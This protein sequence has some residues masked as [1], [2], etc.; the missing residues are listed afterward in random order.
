[1]KIVKLA[2][3][4]TLTAAVLTGFL[5]AT[6]PQRLR[7]NYLCWKQAVSLLS[8]YGSG[9]V[10]FVADID[11]IKYEGNSGNYVDNNVF[12][13]GAF[14]KHI[15]F[16][17]RDLL[18][19]VYGNEGIFIDVGANTGQHSLVLSRHAKQ[20]HAFEPWEPVLKRF[21][22]MVEING[23]KNLT[24]HAYGLGDE[25]SKKPFFK[26]D[27]KN[28]GTGSFVEGFMPQNSY[29]GELEI[30]RG[31]D[32]LARQRITAVSVIKMDIEGYEKPALQGLRN[33]MAKHRPI[34]VFELTA[35]PKSPVSIK[36]KEELSALFPEQ[37]EFL[38]FGDKSDRSTGAYFLEPI[39]G[40][41]RF[42]Q[43][44][45]YDLVAYPA[46]RRSSIARQG[47]VR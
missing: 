32:A 7:R 26:P 6:D 17:L 2:I 42:D 4:A 29:E 18:Q 24:I 45:Q 23:V 10:D 36:G 25:N 3:A 28:L 33:T 14:D 44:E 1:M 37:Y 13:D 46:E 20:V 39:D 34:V 22:R 27:E 21:R 31:D 43:A 47:P 16:L 38:V 15:L 5:F 8:C 11:G 35:N 40:I 19:T 9:A 12:Y 30:Q 41:V